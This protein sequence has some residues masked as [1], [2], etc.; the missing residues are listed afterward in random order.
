MRTDFVQSKAVQ[1]VREGLLQRPE[2]TEEIGYGRLA[3]NLRAITIGFDRDRYLVQIQIAIQKA[4][5]LQAEHQKQLKKDPDEANYD[6]ASDS[7]SDSFSEQGRD[8]GLPALRVLQS[9]FSSMLGVTPKCSGF[10]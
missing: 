5:I 9:M 6:S 2:M 4:E 10:D 7:A 3:S 8:Y 1:M